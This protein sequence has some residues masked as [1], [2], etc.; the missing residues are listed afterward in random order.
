MLVYLRTLG[1]KRLAERKATAAA[2]AK[3]KQEAKGAK[4][5]QAQT[6]VGGAPAINSNLS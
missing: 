6:K 2:K 1:E 5:T 4:K 3:L